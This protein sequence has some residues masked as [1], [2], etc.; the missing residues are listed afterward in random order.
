MDERHGSW[1]SC[2][3]EKRRPMS[4]GSWHLDNEATQGAIV[5]RTSAFQQT[6]RLLA[7]VAGTAFTPP[8]AKQDQRKW[9]AFRMTLSSVRRLRP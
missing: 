6:V 5:A 2:S 7:C 4:A 1:P 3:T 8:P 9:S